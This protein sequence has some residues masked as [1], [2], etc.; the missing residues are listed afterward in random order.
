MPVKQTALREFQCPNEE[1]NNEYF[2]TIMCIKRMKRLMCLFVYVFA[3]RNFHFGVF[4][5]FSTSP[6][7][8]PLSVSLFFACV[9]QMD[10]PQSDDI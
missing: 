5:P 10:N 9:A 1:N 8:P 2:V 3:S 6:N 7:P 4:S